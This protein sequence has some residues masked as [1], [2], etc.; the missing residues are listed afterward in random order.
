MRVQVFKCPFTGKLFEQDARDEYIQ[1]LFKVRK[2][3]QETR[4]A[5]RLKMERLEWIAKEKAAIKRVEDIPDWILDNQEALM[6]AYNRLTNRYEKF[7]PTDEFRDIKFDFLHYSDSASN[8]HC[9]PAGKP[10][11]WGCKPDL[12]RGYPGWCGNV[13]GS[14][15]RESKHQGQYPYSDLLQFLQI[16]TGSGG[17]GNANWRYG[18]TIFLEEWPSLQAQVDANKAEEARI[19][20]END[21]R[22]VIARLKGNHWA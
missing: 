11:N 18:F 3:K 19:K 6:N 2:N 9:A 21:Q 14:L 4:Q 7:F 15:H 5:Q 12:P 16:H 13:Q 10:M 20:Y 8:T 22:R 1:H 17:G